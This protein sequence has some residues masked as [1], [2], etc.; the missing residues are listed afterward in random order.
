MQ[1]RKLRSLKPRSKI[2]SNAKRH[3]TEMQLEYIEVKIPRNSS[4]QRQKT[5]NQDAGQTLQ[6]MFDN[7]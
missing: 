5:F 6:A 4:E 2:V 3:L 7:R 1:V